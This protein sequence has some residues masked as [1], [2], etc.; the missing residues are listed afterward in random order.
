MFRGE[1]LFTWTNSELSPFTSKERT[2]VMKLKWQGHGITR[3]LS[4]IYFVLASVFSSCSTLKPYEK[5]YLLHPVMDDAATSK[6]EGSYSSKTR[7]RERLAA[8]G[9]SAG[10]TSCPTCGG[11]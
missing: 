3:S 11:K 9:V 1:F 4:C 10:S 2:G 8:F 6:L 5:E 7:P